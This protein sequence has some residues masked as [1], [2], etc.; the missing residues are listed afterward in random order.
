MIKMFD[1]GDYRYSCEVTSIPLIHFGPKYFKSAWFL[2][3]FCV[4]QWWKLDHQLFVVHCS[5][6]LEQD[7]YDAQ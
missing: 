3:I 4:E 6:A 1:Q 7:S 5:F 2:Y